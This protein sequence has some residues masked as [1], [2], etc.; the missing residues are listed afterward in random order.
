[1]PSGGDLVVL[2]GAAMV[3][4]VRA[5]AALTDAGIG[6]YVVVGGVAV[7]VR[8]G[9]AHRATADVDTVVDETSPPDAIEALLAL[10]DTIRDP[11]AEHRVLVAG[12]K[13]EILGVGPLDEPD[14]EGIPTKDALFVAS[15]VWALD[16]ATPITVVAGV[17]LDVRA[18]A[19][20]AT[21]AALI[22]MKLHAI[23]D[24]SN[25]S[26][27]HKRAGDAWDIYRILVDLDVDGSVRAAFAAASGTLRYLVRN[28]AER[29]LVTAAA[30]THGWLRAGDDAMAAVTTEELRLVGRA[31]I[32]AIDQQQ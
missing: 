20:F 8:L 13:V 19:P 28:A 9:Q 10:P 31:F 7:S 29:V 16:T 1:M 5:V 2:P 3:P 4:L 25:S 17:D 21:P 23:E 15:H 14:L 27:Q 18:T 30:R 24:R 11:S 26:G 22:A 12:T 6:R 32:N